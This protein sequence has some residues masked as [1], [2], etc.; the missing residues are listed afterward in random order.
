MFFSKNKNKN[1][2][3]YIFFNLDS[4]Y[5]IDNLLIRLFY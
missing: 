4:D 3:D 2:H 1:K 5:Y